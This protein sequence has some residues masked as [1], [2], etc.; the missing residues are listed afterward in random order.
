MRANGEAL[1]G[2]D[3]Q[4]LGGSMGSGKRLFMITIRS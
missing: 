2:W 3:E 1:A 4:R